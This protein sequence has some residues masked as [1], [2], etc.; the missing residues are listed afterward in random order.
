MIKSV[1]QH[2]CVHFGR[3]SQLVS[4]FPNS[5]KIT[6]KE[7]PICQ[8][9]AYFKVKASVQPFTV[10]SYDIMERINIDSV[11]PFKADKNGN[12]YIIVIIDCFSRWVELYPS[13]DTSSES[14][15]KAILQWISRFGTPSQI[16]SDN[17]TQYHNEMINQLCLLTGT[18][19]LLTMPYSKEENSM[20]ERANREA[21]RYLR[22]IC[23]LR[24]DKDNWS[25]YLPI[26][27][28]I[29]NS[30]DKEITG[31]APSDLL[32]AGAIQLNKHIFLQSQ[33]IQN[34]KSITIDQ[35]LKDKYE[36]Q[37]EAISKAE[38]R[39]RDHDI[40][41]TTTKETGSRTIYAKGDKVLKAYP[42]NT[43]GGNGKPSKLYHN[44][45]G[46]FTVEE[47]ISDEMYHLRNSSGRLIQN[48]SVHLLKPFEYDHARLNPDEEALY[49][50]EEYD[51]ERIISHRGSFTKKKSLQIEVKWIGYEQTTWV[52][53]KNVMKNIHMHEYL[54]RLGLEK[55]IPKSITEEMDA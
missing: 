30:L 9:N 47:V 46:P 39:Q 50:N 53:W 7:C 32:Y 34:I 36:F 12:E 5:S 4:F 54:R 31:Y 51:V 20:V 1:I 25:E 22:D 14:A 43:T 49:D 52:P 15:A 24:K 10:G 28:R 38:Q 45:T 33:E 2:S 44:F 21:T 6:I 16:L 3:F 41:H 27:Q 19:Q 8:K 18:Q 55:Y 48:V 26:A 11:G 37:K 23:Y 13:K 35:W 29:M 40:N 17:G 42:P